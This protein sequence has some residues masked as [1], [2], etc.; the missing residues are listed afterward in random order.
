MF[1]SFLIDK[2]EKVMEKWLGI[3]GI[4]SFDS[5]VSKYLD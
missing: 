3:R 4:V 1:S 5:T 2:N